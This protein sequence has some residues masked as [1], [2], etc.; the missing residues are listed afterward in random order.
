[1]PSARDG[2]FGGGW[3]LERRVWKEGWGSGKKGGGSGKK[4]WGSGKKEWGS[5]KKGG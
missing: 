5:E 2:R 1:M 3:G 4:E